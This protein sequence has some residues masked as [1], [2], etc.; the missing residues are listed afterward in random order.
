MPVLQKK[1]LSFVGKQRIEILLY[2]IRSNQKAFT[3]SLYLLCKGKEWQSRHTHTQRHVCRCLET[4]D[5][6]KET[7][8]KSKGLQEKRDGIKQFWFG[9]LGNTC[10]MSRFKVNLIENIF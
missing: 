5:K 8:K 4:D 3:A 9:A 1:T 7:G 6:L 10:Y 2:D